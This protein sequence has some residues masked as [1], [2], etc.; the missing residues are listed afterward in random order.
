MINLYSYDKNSALRHRK[1]DEEN[2]DTG[3][4]KH[5]ARLLKKNTES[6]GRPIS[7]LDVGC[8]TGR[9]FYCLKNVSNLL[10]IDLSSYMLEQARNP[11]RAER[12][13]IK[14]IELMCADI[15]EVD[16]SDRSFDM[17]YS[18]GVLGE[19][20]PFDLQLCKKLLA[21][22]KPEGKLFITIVDIH[23]RCSIEHMTILNRVL[24]KIFKF[25]PKQLKKII[26]RC[27]SSSYMSLTEI[28]E[29]FQNAGADNYSISSYVHPLATGWQG[30]HYDCMITK[31]KNIEDK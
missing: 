28:E 9:F 18:I 13:G 16:L 20:A 15:C 24:S 23:S 5:W 22:L 8:G 1:S 25:A 19:C 10:G 29:C 4:R 2:V 27:L 11:V 30:T 17:I 31:N 3:S 21:L 14:N 7:V 6:F 26:N 12:V